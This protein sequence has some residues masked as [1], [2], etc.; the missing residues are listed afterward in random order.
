[1]TPARPRGSRPARRPRA[2]D[3]R[4]V[5]PPS[6]RQSARDAIEKLTRERG[7]SGRFPRAVARAAE[8]AAE[9]AQ[10]AAAAPRRRDLRSLPTF[11][12]D[13]QSAR[14]FDDALSAQAGAGDAVRVWVHIADVSAYVREGSALDEEA[15]T[16]AF[17]VYVPGAVEP[18]LPAALSNDACSLMPGADRL[19]VTAE[20]EL[21]GAK[22]QRA[23]FYRSLIRSDARLDYEQVDRIFSGHEPASEPWAA[24]LAT[25]RHAA[26][27]LQDARERGGALVVDAPEPEFA[28]DGDG[29]VSEIR[30]RAQ[31][32]S[33][34][35]IEHLMIA[36]N[37]AVAEHLSRRRIPCLYRVH[38]RPDAQSILRLADQLASLD[39]ST[40]ALPDSMS[41]AQAAEAVG[42]ISRLVDRTVKRR[43]HGRL[44]LGSLVLRS[45]KQ[46]YYSPRNL[47]HAGLHSRAYCHFTSPIRRYPDLICHRALLSVL[48]EAERAPRAR[49][50]A[51]LGA[52]TSDRER[53]AMDVERDADDV[54][55]CFALEA[56]LYE[57]GWEQEFQGEVVGLIGAGAFVAFG[58]LSATLA[59]GAARD[60]AGDQPGASAHVFEGLLPV[61]HLRSYAPQADSEPDAR[62][63]S[64]PPGGE[65]WELNEVGT[66]LRGR[67]TGAAIRLGDVIA[68]RVARVEAARGRAE[69]LPAGSGEQG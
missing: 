31:T 69:L 51:E 44:A 16:R 64:A 65:W 10:P 62:R 49:E 47:G 39:V 35:V 24:A 54:A 2:Q 56:L 29:N 34:R 46:A 41:S 20:L 67:Q 5:W 40:P 48:G 1:V 57:R 37:E 28:F 9:R 59:A 18:M 55:R 58:G 61:R 66:I 6:E 32:E 27:A 13:P 68:V 38:E 14:D 22:V 21:R 23:S 19:A 4:V 7:L 43:G 42:E 60:G 15:R 17:S 45:L 12:I 50:L 30:M 8:Q 11:T 52:W 36:A 3:A 26:R 25:A 33:H 53:A 63:S